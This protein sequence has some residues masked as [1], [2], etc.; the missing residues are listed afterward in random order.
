MFSNWYK[1][2]PLRPRIYDTGKGGDTQAQYYVWVIGTGEAHGPYRTLKSA[3][4]FARIG[5]T[6]GKHDRSVTRGRNPKNV[7]RYYQSGTGASLVHNPVS[8]HTYRVK[9]WTGPVDVKHYAQ[10]LRRSG[11]SNVVE[12]TEHVYGDITVQTEDPAGSAQRLRVAAAWAL[13]DST[14]TTAL[15]G[16]SVRELK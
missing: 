16:I 6:K 13:F 12:G 10:R 14:T 4:T 9:A 7:V 8:R 5:A 3:K 1:S 15:R 11:F 2:N